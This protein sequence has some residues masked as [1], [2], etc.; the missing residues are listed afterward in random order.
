MELRRGFRVMI[1]DK[2]ILKLVATFC[3]NAFCNGGILLAMV[4]LFSLGLSDHGF[5]FDP[6]RNGIIFTL[7]SLMGLAWQLI[8]FKPLL[9]SI[10][11]LQMYKLGAVCIGTA[12][13]ALPF[14]SLIYWWFGYSIWTEVVLWVLLLV[15]LCGVVIGWMVAGSVLVTM[16]TNATRRTMQGLVQGTNQSLSSACRGIGPVAVGLLFSVSLSVPPRFP[17]LAFWVMACVYGACCAVVMTFTSEEVARIQGL[18]PPPPLHS[19]LDPDIDADVGADVADVDIIKE[20][21]RNEGSGT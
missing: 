15:L 8:F 4:L 10:G 6:N 18:L 5:G 3:L 19:D 9:F 7:F 14:L 12:S 13:S 2:L 16:Q 17:G 20:Q 21:E 1:R 11:G